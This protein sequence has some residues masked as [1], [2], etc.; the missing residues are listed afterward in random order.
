MF[1]G[2]GG[3]HY[4]NA[5]GDKLVNYSKLYNFVEVN[6]TFYQ[7]PKFSIVKKWRSKVPRNFM[8]AIKANK[9]LSHDAPFQ[10]TESNLKI[11]DY[12]LKICK[13]LGSS[14]LLFQTP[15]YYHPSKQN[16]SKAALFFEHLQ[17]K[18]LELLWEIRGPFSSF[19]QRDQFKSLCRKYKVTHVTD[20]LRELPLHVEHTFY[21]RIFGR[22][23]GNKWE[24]SNKEIKD[25]YSFI[26]PIET[27]RKVVVSF[28]TMRMENDAIKFGQYNKTNTL[29]SYLPEIGVKSALKSI[30]ELN[31][32]PISKKILL[33]EHG[34]K[35]LQV[36][37]NEQIR[38]SKVLNIIE[39]RIYNNYY[40]LKGQIQEIFSKNFNN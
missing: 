32:Y 31:Q 2:C 12:L 23:N 3:W 33:A 17:G 25:V 9:V 36:N 1:I 34:W 13:L 7:L 28:H 18:N 35:L 21:T 4:F 10:V 37:E 24:L 5:P 6:T 19:F 29:L 15:V 14:F 16:L 38:L 8:F 40:D 30:K 27:D 39:D 22:G 20:I 11:L 26:K